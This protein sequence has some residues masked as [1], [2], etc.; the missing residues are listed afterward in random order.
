MEQ[1]TKISH[2]TRFHNLTD[3]SQLVM[4]RVNQS[5]DEAT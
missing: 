4:D 2:C 5:G 3:N 1:Q